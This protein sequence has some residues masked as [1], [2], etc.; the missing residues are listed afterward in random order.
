MFD[1]KDLEFGLFH[2][3]PANNNHADNFPTVNM[4]FIITYNL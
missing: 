3:F 2:L 1:M 4:L